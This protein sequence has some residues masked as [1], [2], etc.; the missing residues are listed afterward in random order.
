MS[1][2]DKSVLVTGSARGIGAAIAIEFAREGYGYIGINYSKDKENALKTAEIIQSI[3]ADV[4]LVQA[5]VRKDEECRKMIS[6]FVDDF[7]KIDVLV[8][9][10]GG[11]LKVPDGEYMDM[12]VEYWDSQI[13]L[14]L[15]AAAYCSRYALKDMKSKKAKGRIINISS[16]LSYRGWVQRKLLPYSSAKGGLNMFTSTLANEVA[17]YGIVVNGIAPGF[18]LT[19]ATSRYNEAQKQQYIDRIPAGFLGQPEDIAHLAVFLA[20]EVKTRYII[21]QTILVDGGQLGDGSL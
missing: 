4:K 11:A 9:N 16:Q 12:P 1:N 21:G 13:A 18:I 17:K 7:G 5:D 3:G 10:A 15:S 6:G 19:Q 2:K 8:N 20:D 14:N